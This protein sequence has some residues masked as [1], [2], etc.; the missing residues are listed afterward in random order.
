MDP[1]RRHSMLEV[2]PKANEKIQEF[3]KGKEEEKKIRI[4]LSQGG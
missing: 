1:A 2:T 3:F 4:F